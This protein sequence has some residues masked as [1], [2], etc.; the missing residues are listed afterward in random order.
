M[1]VGAGANFLLDRLQITRGLGVVGS[2][3]DQARLGYLLDDQVKRFQDGLK[4]LIRPPFSECQNPMLRITALAEVGILG[5]RSET[6][7]SPH[8][9]RASPVFLDQ[10][11]SVRRQSYR[12]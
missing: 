6:S 9:N 5:P 8:I 3:N 7:V 10:D 2:G 12:D 4:L 11:T 1:H